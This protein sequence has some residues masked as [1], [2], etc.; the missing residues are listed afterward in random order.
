LSVTCVPGDSAPGKDD[1]L[2]LVP[3]TPIVKL[4]AV[5][6]PPSSLITCLITISFGATSLFVMVQTF[7]TPA[8]T[9]TTP[10]ALQSP[11]KLV[12]VYPRLEGSFSL[13][14]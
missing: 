12:C 11:L 4:D 2:G 7:S 1:G 9:D 14:V 13:T 3:V 10:L 5:D 8:T 6:V